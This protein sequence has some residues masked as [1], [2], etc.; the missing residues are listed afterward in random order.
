MSKNL[1]LY[2]LI[3]ETWLNDDTNTVMLNIE[4]YYID[5]DLRL[6]RKDT[7]NGMFICLLCLY[8]CMFIFLYVYYVYM[9]V[10]LYVYMFI[11]FICFYVYYVYMFVWLYVYYVYMFICLYVYMFICLCV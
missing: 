9:F 8:V 10:C 4:G 1:T 7:L 6:D 3:A 5:P 11:M 2:V